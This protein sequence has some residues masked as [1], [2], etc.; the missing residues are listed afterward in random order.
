MNI[1]TYIY[2]L[3]RQLRVGTAQ[4][5]AREKLMYARAYIQGEESLVRYR[6]RRIES[7]IRK[8][9]SEGAETRLMCNLLKNDASHEFLTEFAEH[10]TYVEECKAKVDA[11]ML[12]Y[13]TELE[14]ELR[15]EAQQ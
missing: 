13:K 11:E 2:N 8:R 1:K 7:E 14:A 4:E 15:R 9:Y 12:A 6:D 10:E 3:S 5:D